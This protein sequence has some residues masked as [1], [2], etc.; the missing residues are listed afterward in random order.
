MTTSNSNSNQLPTVGLLS[1]STMLIP[2]APVDS[3]VSIQ[4]KQNVLTVSYVVKIAYITIGVLGIVTNLVV[5]YVIVKNKKMRQHAPDLFLLN[6]SVADF[7]T[8]AFIIG[9]ALSVDV[10]VQ[11]Y[12]TQGDF[13]C[14]VWTTGMTV[15][16]GLLA[17]E[18]NLVALS[19]DVYFEIVYPVRHK[20]LFNRRTAGCCIAAVWMWSLVWNTIIFVPQ[21]G[22]ESNICL[23]FYNFTS[24]VA[25]PALGLFNLV[26]KVIIPLSV[27]LFCYLSMAR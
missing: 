6:Q 18:Y 23:S 2:T 22:L 21:S 26:L 15:W 14:R 19:I 16:I 9:F 17:S 13:V 4:P 1:Q 25:K 27:F 3:L 20:L 5:I 11:F 7:W 24:Y 12:G 10:H 8:A